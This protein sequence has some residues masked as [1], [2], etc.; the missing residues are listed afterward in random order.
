MIFNVILKSSAALVCCG[1]GLGTGSP[2]IESPYGDSVQPQEAPESISRA[3]ASLPPEQMFELMKQMKVTIKY[4]QCYFLQQV[5]LMLCVMNVH[6]FSV[7]LCVQNSPQEARNMLLQNPQLAYA[8]L[9]AQ[10]VMRIVDPEI[11]LV[12]DAK[13]QI[14]TV[15]L[16]LCGTEMNPL[17][18]CSTFRKCC[19]VNL[20]SSL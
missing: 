17:P 13:C 16:V 7:Q 19:T 18:M 5:Y 4:C 9:Q 11:A 10:V 20:Q 3:V 2:I 1:V 12:I 6:P 14:K 15:K 8:L